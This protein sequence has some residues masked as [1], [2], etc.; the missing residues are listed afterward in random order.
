[1]FPVGLTGF[2]DERGQSGFE[3]QDRSGQRVA[4]GDQITAAVDPA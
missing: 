4:L 2:R 3:Q 1:M